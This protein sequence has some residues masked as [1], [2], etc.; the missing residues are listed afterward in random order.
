MIVA[1]YKPLG[2]STHRLALQVG[3]RCGEKATHTGTLDPMAEGVVV[4][5]TDEDRFNKS[6]HSESAKTYEF[7]VAFG[8]ST[9]SLDLLGKIEKVDVENIDLPTLT[10]AVE[11]WAQN[12]PGVVIQQTPDFSARRVSGKSAFDLAKKK[13]E[14]PPK[15]EEVKIFSCRI[16]DVEELSLS[17]LTQQAIA[18]ISLVE[19]NFRQQEIIKMWSE[20]GENGCQQKDKLK[21][22]PPS[23]KLP[24]FKFEV[25]TSRRTYIRALAPQLEKLTKIPAVV[26]SIERTANGNFEIADCICLLNP[27]S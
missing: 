20:V 23:S 15:L 7:T 9:D 27:K 26:T 11:Q 3:V 17:Q 10:L 22:L 6:L 21:N 19:G 1:I 14:M 5:L 2:A 16:L 25:T 12:L 13:V 18:K 8:V 4:V 24:I